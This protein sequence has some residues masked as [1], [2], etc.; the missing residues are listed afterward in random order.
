MEGSGNAKHSRTI[1]GFRG[2]TEGAAPPPFFK[3]FLYDHNP[4]N[5]PENRFIKFSLILSTETLT[6]L[7]FA[8]RKH[9]QCCMLHVLK[10]EAFIQ[11]DSGVGGGVRTRPPLYEFSGSTPEDSHH[12]KG[13]IVTHR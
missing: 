1:G 10:S 7:H 13:P 8:P 11:R 12:S 4:V 3:T 2:G 5:R 9:P 6:L